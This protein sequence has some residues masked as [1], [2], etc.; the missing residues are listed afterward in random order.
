[1]F[2]KNK[3]SQSMIDA[4]NK[5]LATE[6]KKEQLDEAFPTVADAQKR[7]SEPKP[8]GGSGIKLGTRYG[9]GKQ[10]P[11]PEEDDDEPKA[12]RGK[13]GAHKTRRTDTKLYKEDK[14]EGSKEDKEEDKKLA[15]KH[16]MT[17]AQWEK[18]AADKKHD[19]DEELKGN[20]HKIDA[21]KNGKVDAQDFEILRS[22]KKKM[23]EGYAFAERLV[24]SMYGK[25][26]ALP[27]D[28]KEMTDAQKKKREE[29]VMAM[30]KDSE[31]LKKR[32]GSRW[33]DVAYATAT[34]QAMKETYAEEVEVEEEIDPNVRTKDSL[35][36]GNK[37]TN[38]KDDTG[39]G[40]DGRSTKV[41]FKAGPMSEEKEDEKEDE[42]HEDEK[43][44][45]ALIK[46]MVKKDSL[47]E[48][49]EQLD[50]LKKSTL[51]SYTDKAAQ[52][53]VDNVVKSSKHDQ[54]A[55]G[56]K[57]TGST[58]LAKINQKLADKHQAKA[59]KRVAGMI[60]AAEKMK[61]ETEPKKLKSFSSMK[62]EMIGKAGM[63]SEKKDEE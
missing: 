47:K 53:A 4:V 10:A 62:K 5:V 48:D 19:M 18:S 61:E 8:S 30:K 44:D 57:K 50:E 37:P 14:W 46:K 3:V 22:K 2:A 54:I 9:G 32:Y 7:A 15:K 63:T 39:P 16:G 38:Q 29:I 60:K 20:Q 28:E 27:L 21:N 36:G 25:K 43:E 56:A 1:M 45:K 13:Y 11:E 59:N 58:T 12:K 33:K 34:K 55:Y 42:G 49:A 17:L 31:G 41:K 52:D 35:S 23:T 24:E 26:S 40:S 6:Q 51:K